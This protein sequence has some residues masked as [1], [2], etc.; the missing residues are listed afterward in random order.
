MG[1]CDR[2]RAHR[3]RLVQTAAFGRDRARK[4]RRE[5]AEPLVGRRSDL[6]VS[7]SKARLAAARARISSSSSDS[8]KSSSACSTRSPS[9]ASSSGWIC[10]CAPTATAAHWCCT[11]T[12]SNATTRNRVATG[13]ATRGYGRAR[14]PATWCPDGGSIDDLKPFVFRRYLDFGAIQSLREMKGRI[15]SERS[16]SAMRDDVKLGPGGIREVEFVAQMHQLIWAGRQPSLQCT[17]VVETLHALAS[18]KLMSRD[19]ADQLAAAYRFLRNV[20]HRLQAMRDEQTQLLPVAELDRMR[21]AAGMGFAD[22]V[23]FG[24]ALAEQRSAVAQ[25]FDSVIQSDDAGD[26][27]HWQPAWLAGDVPAL[28]A[29]LSAVG[30]GEPDATAALINRLCTARDRPW[31]GGESRARVDALVPKLLGEARSNRASGPHAGAARAV[32]RS[33][34]AALCLLCAAAREPERAALAGRD[35][36]CEPLARRRIEPPSDVARRAARSGAALHDSRHR[37]VARRTAIAL[38]RCGAQR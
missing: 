16:R 36:Q 9:M 37:G 11:S 25:A 29:A 26:V 6:R 23:Q 22:F 12:Q 7:G 14:A 5:G 24:S 17:G 15:D 38:E 4:A 19:Q 8:G 3:P 33:D 30:F 13:N 2:W 18:H 21:V 34:G 1:R 31:V 10:D 28:A 32:A 27:D 35:L 20:E